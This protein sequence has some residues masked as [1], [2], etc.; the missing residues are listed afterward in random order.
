MAAGLAATRDPIG[1]GGHESES[2]R[3]ALGSGVPDRDHRGERQMWDTREYPARRVEC[4]APAPVTL[5]EPVSELDGSR[6]PPLRVLVVKAREAGYPALDAQRV[7]AVA[8][9]AEQ[10]ALVVHEI[11]VVREIPHPPIP[12]PTHHL[13]IPEKQ[14][15]G[16]GVREFRWSQHHITGGI[17]PVI[18]RG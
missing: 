12:D 11:L 15:Q 5:S 7:E 4:D 2:Q 6:R 3:Q 1:F 14:V 8:L 17:H 13:G 9:G 18:V 16:F 10:L